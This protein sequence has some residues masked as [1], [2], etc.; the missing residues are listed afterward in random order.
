VSHGTLRESCCEVDVKEFA[1]KLK[2]TFVELSLVLVLFEVSF[3][4]FM[5]MYFKLIA[6]CLL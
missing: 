5:F 6:L 2:S 1:M 4:Y 3:F